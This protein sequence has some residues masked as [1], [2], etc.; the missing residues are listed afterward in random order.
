[1]W[2]LKVIFVE[3]KTNLL[4]V[5]QSSWI[6]QFEC[7]IALKSSEARENITQNRNLKKLFSL[8]S[9]SDPFG[10][11]RDLWCDLRQDRCFCINYFEEQERRGTQLFLNKYF[12]YFKGNKGLSNEVSTKI[13]WFIARFSWWLEHWICP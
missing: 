7:N 12:G 13:V 9:S 5:H 4:Q 6:K 11:S 10:N 1:M 2:A 8:E 3:A